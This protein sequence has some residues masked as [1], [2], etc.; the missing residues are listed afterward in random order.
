MLSDINTKKL[1]IL[2]SSCT[3]DN[4]KL[5]EIIKEN[6]KKIPAFKYIDEKEQYEYLTEKAKELKVKL[7]N[8]NF[9]NKDIGLLYDTEMGLNSLMEEFLSMIT[10]S[11]KAINNLKNEK[12]IILVNDIEIVKR[13]DL[14]ELI[15]FIIEKSKTNLAMHIE[16]CENLK[17]IR[18]LKEPQLISLKQCIEH[19]NSVESLGNITEN[20][21]Y[22]NIGIENIEDIYKSNIIL[23]IENFSFSDKLLINPE[24]DFI[25]EK[26]IE[27]LIGK[28]KLYSIRAEEYNAVF[29][30]AMEGRARK[31]K[32]IFCGETLGF[33]EKNT[34]ASC[35][36]HRKWEKFI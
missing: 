7:D 32:C 18:E 22:T 9:D 4:S 27:Q 17:A 33:F 23:S 15:K 11:N 6:I 19:Y 21:N 35:K 5:K 12:G 34:Y 31:K 13:D 28:D 16:Y 3:V 10:V 2:L 29:L 1:L 8:F 25:S 20:K 24:P 26:N 36:H 30:E 14:E